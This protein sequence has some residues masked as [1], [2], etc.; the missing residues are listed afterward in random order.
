MV[1]TLKSGKQIKL[2]DKEVAASKK[3]INKFIESVK[4]SSAANE[5]PSLYLTLLIVMETQAGTLLSTIEEDKL[6]N[7]IE[8]F[9]VEE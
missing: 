2:N 7:M 8:A 3:M 6:K 4:A 9:S 5:R 1:C